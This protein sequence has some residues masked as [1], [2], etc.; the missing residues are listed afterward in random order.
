MPN[1]FVSYRRDDSSTISGWIHEKL[2]GRYGST[3]VFKDID[4]IAVAE[5]FQ[6]AI[7]R[8]LRHCDVMIAIIGPRWLGV[9]DDGS[10]KIDRDRDWIRREI[11]MALQLDIPIIPVLVERGQM[12]PAQ[13][14]PE[15][16]RDLTRLNA[17]IVE[18]GPDFES[19]V[20]RLMTAIDRI[21]AP[22][23]RAEPRPPDPTPPGAAFGAIPVAPSKPAR[24]VLRRVLLPFAFKPT[25]NAWARIAKAY[26]NLLVW[27]L[28]VV[29]ASIIL[30]LVT[31][32]KLPS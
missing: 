3:A 32:G 24:A 13:K 16:I 5:D 1:I 30:S 8:A 29:A 19:Q 28:Y 18:V 22:S 9:E 21:E 4:S 20:S 27:C 15:G 2:S 7:G 12:P 25:D 23:P 6:R 31:T 14:I 26:F 10:R 17:L 11:E